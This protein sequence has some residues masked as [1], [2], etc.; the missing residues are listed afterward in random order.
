MAIGSNGRREP[1]DGA[2]NGDHAMTSDQAS[3]TSQTPESDQEEP[4]ESA[5]IPLK[6]KGMDIASQIRSVKQAEPDL[7]RLVG[8][9]SASVAQTLGVIEAIEATLLHKRRQIDEIQARQKVLAREYRELGETLDRANR[10][11]AHQFAGIIRDLEAN[12]PLAKPAGEAASQTSGS[13]T[14]K[15]AD[16]AAET[17]GRA[18]QPPAQGAPDGASENAPETDEA[19]GLDLDPTNLPPVP[20]FLGDP[21]KPLDREEGGTSEDSGSGAR[22]WWSMGKKS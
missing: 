9:Y 12:L 17:S 22:G 3:L 16:D 4:P 18:A 10:D 7:A 5:K 20:E 1:P 11:L 21:R 6:H 14:D 19:S 8:D 13:V 15:H 2:V